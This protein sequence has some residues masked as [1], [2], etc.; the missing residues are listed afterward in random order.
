[1]RSHRPPILAALVAVAAILIAG[2]GGS[3]PGIA[4]VGGSTSTSSSTA[5]RSGGSPTSAQLLQEQRDA[6]RFASCMRSHGIA[7]FPDP[8]AAPVAFKR[9]FQS[10]TPAFRSANTA[11]AHLLPAG[12][13]QQSGSPANTQQQ[14]DALL[15][16]ARCLRSHGFPSFPDPNGSGE[17]SHEM[18]ARA[19][20]DL[21]EPALVAAADTCTSVTHGVITRAIV[22][23][24]VA[25]H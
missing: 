19:G 3:S 11:C 21:H 20:I 13:Q 12:H 2:C 7:N 5:S 24:F 22:A 23:H 17:L 15:A 16:F 9:A 18:L 6:T 14:I 10:Q 4:N 8:T 1:M 25:G